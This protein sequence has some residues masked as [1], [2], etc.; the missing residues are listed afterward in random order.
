MN[1]N[2]GKPEVGTVNVVTLDYRGFTPEELAE[3]AL[4]R[5]ISVG[6]ASHPAIIAQALA[7][8]D[9]IRKVLVHYMRMAQQSEQG[10][11]YG[12]LAKHGQADT[13]E[14]IKQAF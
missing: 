11:I 9:D 6:E 7:F 2:S 1:G 10:N 5:I 3:M 13:A 14:M 4:A 12:R 8:K